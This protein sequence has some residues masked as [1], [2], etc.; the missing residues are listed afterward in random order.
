MGFQRANESNPVNRCPLPRLWGRNP[1]TDESLRLRAYHLFSEVLGTDAADQQRILGERCGSD[2]PLRAEVQRLLRGAAKADFPTESLRAGMLATPESLSGQTIGRFRLCEAL[3]SGGA[4]V[5]YRAERIGDVAQVVAIKLLSA[6]L[7]EHA[8]ALFRREAQ[9]LARIEHPCIARLI[10]TGVEQRRA[11]IAM[12]FVRGQRI[13]QFCQTQGLTVRQIVALVDQLLDAVAAAH[14]LLVVHSDIKP[15]NVLVDEAGKP[16][17]VDFGIATALRD[18]TDEVRTAAEPRSFTPNFAAPE[19]IAGGPITV[20]TD[21]YGLGALTYRLLTGTTIHG[22]APSSPD[23]PLAV[24]ERAITL[25]S[26]TAARRGMPSSVLRALRGDL[27]AILAKAL[28]HRPEDRYATA[29]SISR[30]LKAYLQRR[31]VSLLANKPTY[32]LTRFI[33]RNV[34]LVTAA[35]LVVVALAGGGTYAV[36]QYQRAALANQVA[37]RRG[38]FL[39]HF[40]KAANPEHGRR[41]ITVADVLDSA[42]AAADEQLGKEPLVEA[43]ML[44]LIA[45]TDGSLGRY[46]EGLQSN[47]RELNLL[48]ARHAGGNEIGHALLVRA[49]LLR[50]F[51]KFANARAAALQAIAVLPSTADSRPD[52]ANSYDEL[53]VADTNTAREAEAEAFYRKAIATRR[54][55]PQALSAQ[56]AD[57]LTGL[58][59]LQANQGR[60]A[61][62]AAAAAEALEL[63][64]KSAS[65]EDPA[66]LATEQ[67]Y[68]VALNNLHRSEEALPL[69]RDIVARSTRIN[70]PAQSSTVIAEIQLGEVLFDLGRYA[71]AEAVLK[72]A[73]ETSEKAQ[74]PD[75]R[76]TVAAWT[77]Y[78]RAA[79][80]HGTNA[81]EGLEVARRV[82]AIRD[83]TLPPDDWR[84]QWSN[85][86]TIAWCLVHVGRNSEAE[87]MLLKAVAG[88]EAARGSGFW[89]TQFTYRALR[90]LYAATGRPAEAARMIKKLSH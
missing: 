31:P 51:G 72:P 74:G 48:K 64:K 81:A 18:V 43:S 20:A 16:R 75:T 66:R 58:A 5:V 56:N 21:V 35:S 78:A 7:S 25:A 60:Y 2:A 79:C 34:A 55:G 39:E 50:S 47:E 52:L 45:E 82:A 76:N 61:D 6:T 67:I 73:A 49:V 86:T 3:G 4:G 1:M 65:S 63:Q 26:V 83:R 13:D 10:D 41:D 68:A 90:D 36:L 62:S 40:L 89:T 54:L 80:A 38:E 32:R 27:D 33:Q 30:D 37:A 15:A 71:E 42:A 17:L 44:G 11:W 59:V 57:S 69:M 23:Y 14:R 19:Q 88:L 29:E 84:R 28:A 24:T 8:Q 87:P 70:G 85:P 77:D 46:A 9:L 12:E 22:D 53:G